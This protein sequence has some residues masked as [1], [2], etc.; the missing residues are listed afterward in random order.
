MTRLFDFLGAV[1]GLTLLSPGLLLIAALIRLAEGGP[2]FYRQVR[3][4]RGGRPFRIWK[5]RTMVV[6]ADR[7]GRALTVSGDPRVTQTGAWL[8]RWKLDELPQLIN[9]LTGEM[10]FVGPRPELPRYVA[11]YT[12]SQRRVLDLRPG[13][14]D[15][16]SIAYRHESDLLEGHDDPEAYYTGTILPDKI[17]IN[18]D[19]AAR[20]GIWRNVKV[21]LA[22]LGLLAPGRV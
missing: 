12:E 9:V 22:T 8:R 20:A 14:T 21:I 2:V 15:L 19:Y 4:G 16:A 13:I 3:V 6:D 10:G 11:L 1:L 18:L 17:R 5:F 7:I